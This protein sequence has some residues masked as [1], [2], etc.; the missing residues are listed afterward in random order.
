MV[1]TAADIKC[2]IIPGGPIVVA[3]GHQANALVAQFG[4]PTVRHE[5]TL[6]SAVW[7]GSGGD[8]YVQILQANAVVPIDGVMICPFQRYKPY[9]I[10]GQE[11]RGGGSLNGYVID[12]PYDGP[13]GGTSGF[14]LK[15]Y[16]FDFSNR[17]FITAPSAGF[18]WGSE[19]S[20]VPEG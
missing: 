18:A 10:I 19:G 1:L 6:T 13:A 20:F 15:A 5:L 7:G 11:V 12:P 2:V 3:T 9:R 16:T 14:G 17:P 8:D 4:E